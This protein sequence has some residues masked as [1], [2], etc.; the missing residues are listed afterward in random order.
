MQS[1]DLPT[2]ASIVFEAPPPTYSASSTNVAPSTDAALPTNTVFS[3]DDAPTIRDTPP[4]TTA[5]Y[6]IPAPSATVAPSATNAPPTTTTR[7][8][9]VAPTAYRIGGVTLEAPRVELDHL[10]A[11]LALLRTFK[12]LRTLIEDAAELGL[13]GLRMG[14][15]ARWAWFVGLAV[16]RFQRWAAVVRHESLFTWVAT[17]LPPIDVLMVWHAYLLNPGWY[18]EDCVRLPIMETMRELGDRFVHAVAEMGDPEQ[19]RASPERIASWQEQTDTPWDPLEAAIQM[20]HKTIEC[21]SCRAFNEVPYLTTDGTGYA[22]HNFSYYCACGF[23]VTRATLAVRKFVGDLTKPYL[24]SRDPGWSYGGYM[25]GTLHTETRAKATRRAE[26]VKNAILRT[27]WF[28]KWDKSMPRNEWE[29]GILQKLGYSFARARRIVGLAL[30]PADSRL[31]TRIFSAYTDDLPFSIDLVGAVVRQGAFIDKMHEFGWTRPGY[32]DDEEDELVLVHATARYHAF[33]DLMSSSPSSFFVP[34]LDIDL[35]WHSHQLMGSR[36]AGDCIQYVKR[37]VDHD[38]KVEENH[39]ATSFDMTSRAWQE[40]FH[41]PYTHCGCPLPGESIG[42]RLSRLSLG[43]FHKHGPDLSLELLPPARE[44]ALS[45]THPSEHNSVESGRSIFLKWQR[46]QRMD[47]LARRRK[48]D[49]ERAVAGRMD[50]DVYQRGRTHDAAF[51]VPVPF[52][53]PVAACVVVVNPLGPLPGAAPTDVNL[54]AVG[55]GACRVA[56]ASIDALKWSNARCVGGGS[57]GSGGGGGSGRQGGRT[58][59]G[60][61]GG[62]GIGGFPGPGVVGGVGFATGAMIGGPAW[63]GSACGAGFPASCGC[64]SGGSVGGGGGSAGGAG[65]G[66]GGRSGSGCGGGGGG[67]GGSGGVASCGGGGGVGPSC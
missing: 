33:L 62:V 8:T 19:Y 31:P 53:S 32:F 36:Y 13:Q 47:K 4:T 28:R 61:S 45:A 57:G 12:S 50:A 18:A 56:D 48:R 26:V 44:D 17:D 16:E 49:T 65:C 1:S 34:T 46:R 60:R 27:E 15:T 6:T 58:G 22:Q 38:D 59:I 14:T 25:A 41:L 63:T 5:S 40:R 64:G 21:P 24:D 37:Y 43:L 52:Y 23:E 55:A 51:L 29:T 3:T 42:R 20:T 39:L 11:H 66:G 35:V 9:C 54:C 7:P 30:E 67:G 10:R 2:Y